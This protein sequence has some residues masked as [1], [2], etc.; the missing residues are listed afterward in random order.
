MRNAVAVAL[1]AWSPP[2]DDLPVIPAEIG[3]LTGETAGLEHG[4]KRHRF[5]RRRPGLT[6]GE[7]ARMLCLE[8]AAQR[9]GVVV[10]DQYM[11]LSIS[12]RW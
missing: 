2:E 5:E 1:S 8:L 12:G 6:P 3:D 11:E 7:F 10:I 9:F 4:L